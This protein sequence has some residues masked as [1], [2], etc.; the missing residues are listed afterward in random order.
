MTFD[1]NFDAQYSCGKEFDGDDILLMKIMMSL[2]DWTLKFN[3]R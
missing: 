3:I 2:E 1:P